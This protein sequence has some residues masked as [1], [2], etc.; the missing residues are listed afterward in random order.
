[1][2]QM[3]GKLAK[4]G[5]L[6]RAD[7]RIILASAA[8]LPLFWLGL[9]VLGLQRFQRMLRRNHAT[10]E[11]G[12]ALEEIRRMG[13]LVNIAGRHALCPVTCLSRSLLLGWMLQRRGIASQLRIGVRLVN[14]NLDAHAWV[15]CAGVPINDDPNIGNQFA[16]FA[17][18]L[19]AAGAFPSA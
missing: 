6:S 18:P 10:A 9:R 13:T 14:D 17:A 1:M 5:A 15:E 16:P 7:R 11:D 3:T 8:W 19:P 12:P 2:Q 4:F